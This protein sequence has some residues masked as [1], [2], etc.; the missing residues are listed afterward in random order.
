M[1]ALPKEKKEYPKWERR[2]I[3]V[4]ITVNELGTNVYTKGR[5][6]FSIIHLITDQ[7][8]SSAS[9]QHL[10]FASTISFGLKPHK[11]DNKADETKHASITIH[12]VT[13]IKT[14][15]VKTN[16]HLRPEP[17]TIYGH[18]LIKWNNNSTL[19]LKLKDLRIS[20]KSRLG[21]WG[22]YRLLPQAAASQRFIMLIESNLK[23]IHKMKK[24]PPL[25]MIKYAS[26]PVFSF[27]R[28]YKIVRNFHWG[29]T[30]E[31]F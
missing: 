26:L 3:I 24:W 18:Q 29:S 5:L 21:W 2:L 1:K 31:W 10:L 6:I 19:V 14:L 20:L 17:S 25:V 22:V 28:R 27:P 16:A 4:P 8:F 12:I 13:S 30:S 23:L 11:N 15:T 7:I 9:L